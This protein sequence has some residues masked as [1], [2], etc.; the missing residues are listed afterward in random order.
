MQAAAG[1]ASASQGAAAAAAGCSKIQALLAKLREV[2]QEQQQV[3]GAYKGVTKCYANVSA[4]GPRATRVGL[5]VSALMCIA[6]CT[7]FETMGPSY[8]RSSSSRL[9]QDPGT[10]GKAAGGAAGAAAGAASRCDYSNNT[11]TNK[12]TVH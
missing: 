12:R 5:F 3:G 8:I 4:R 7:C 6:V 2:Q 9:Q 10:A 11:T 1:G